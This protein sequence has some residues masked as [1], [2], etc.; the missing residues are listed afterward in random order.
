ML[1]KHRA[2]YGRISM[3]YE[4]L[5]AATMKTA[6]FWVVAPSSLVEDY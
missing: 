6:V 1:Q 5:T 2:K 3:R 4:V